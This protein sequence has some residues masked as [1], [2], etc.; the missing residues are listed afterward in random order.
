MN[1]VESNFDYGFKKGVKANGNWQTTPDVRFEALAIGINL[2]LK[3]SPNLKI[4][5]QSINDLLQSD[6]FSKWTRSDVA[7]NKSSVGN[8]IEGIRDYFLENSE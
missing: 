2:A 3:Q 1:F 4:S 5:K 6:D 8:R 7:N